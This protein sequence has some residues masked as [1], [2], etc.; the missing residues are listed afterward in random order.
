LKCSTPNVIH[1]AYSPDGKTLATGAA[2]GVS[3]WDAA[4]RV[5]RARLPVHT[6]PISSIVFTPDSRIVFTGES[7]RTDNN[8]GDG[9]V[10]AWDVAAGRRMHEWHFGGGGVTCLALA[11]DGRHLAVGL[12]NTVI[13]ILRLAPPRIRPSTSAG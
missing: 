1:C 9:W 10:R 7:P 4:T 8:D 3:L 11:S 2:N 6:H 12:R 13:Y 5:E